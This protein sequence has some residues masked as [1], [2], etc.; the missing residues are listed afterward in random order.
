[1]D[2]FGYLGCGKPVG[3]GNTGGGGGNGKVRQPASTISKASKY[4]SFFIMSFLSCARRMTALPPFGPS[5]VPLWFVLPVTVALFVMALV[6]VGWS[7]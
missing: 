4:F 2:L 6:V 5:P 1:L 3:G 7:R